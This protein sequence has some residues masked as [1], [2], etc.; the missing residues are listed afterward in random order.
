MGSLRDSADR[1]CQK[2]MA[3]HG[4]GD[5]SGALAAYDAALRVDPLAAATH[6]YRGNTLVMLQ[7][8][9]D[10]VLA[11]E[12]C[13]A[14]EPED[15]AARFNRARSLVQLERWRD[16][17]QALDDLVAMHPALPDAW[18]NRAGVQQALGL[19]EEALVSMTRALALKPG[20]ARAL[21]NAGNILLL[22]KRFDE[23][24]QT[25]TQ[26]F[27]AD[28]RNPDVLGA[29]VSASLKGC[30]WEN[31]D[32]ML[33]A[34]LAGIR[35]G[36]PVVPPL[37]LLAV[38]D[39][40][41]LQR[42]CADLNLR[43]TLAQM[44]GA[45]ALASRTYAHSKLRIGYLSSDFRDHPVARQIV[46]LLERHDRSRFE[47]TGFSTG[48]DDGSSL[49]HRVAAACDQFRDIAH[50]GSR[51]AADLIRAS[52]IDIL[53]DLNGQTLG[54]RPAILRRRP[55]P[56]IATY[57][58]YAGTVGG[59]LVDYIIG[60]PHVTPLEEPQVFSEKIVQ[61]PDCFWPSDPQMPRPEPVSR[62][63]L[64]LP[65]DAFVFCCFNAAHKI[66]PAVFDVWLRLLEA[67]PDSLLWLRDNG[68]TVN[69]R[70]QK[71]AQGR[72]M[73]P[74]RLHFAGRM[75]SFAQHLGRQAQDDLFLDTWPY[76][77]HTTAYDALW[78]GLPLVTL[79]GESFSSRVSASFL[80]NLGL[81]ELIA[82][83]PQKYEALVLSLARDR[84][85]LARLRRRLAEVRHETPLFNMDRLAR[86]IEAA[87]LQM[88]ARAARGEAPSAFKVDGL[89]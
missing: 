30:D 60:D 51:E 86:N 44:P 9:E 78:A 49:R 1:N 53:V 3:L 16:A 18:V 56:V 55:A 20:D 27:Q 80:A 40:P 4:A 83:S 43:R 85:S 34:A 11:F 32:Q 66:Q 48:R 33:A 8:V 28:P 65:N 17:L 31:L 46:G 54:W 24:T 58:G 87:Y 63:Q 79:R 50:M 36:I 68:P 64:R 25:L 72:G 39:D 7:R 6:F 23:A 57:L 12:R 77:A 35:H 10:A 67:V 45:P 47:V 71:W 26:A 15:L 21:Y 82:D 61:L 70:L 38:S 52:E 2:G 29:L 73:D 69:A 5:F 84:Q 88:H 76:G 81:S 62:S 19:H 14:L 41:L 22:L 13:L 74:G 59:D 42:Q 89:Q 37:I 75:E